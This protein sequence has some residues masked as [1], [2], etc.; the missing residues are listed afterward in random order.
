MRDFLDEASSSSSPVK[1][2]DDNRRR[3]LSSSLAVRDEVELREATAPVD[4]IPDE[5][6]DVEPRGKCDCV[7]H[8][9]A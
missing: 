5:Y 6:D 7:P 1:D 2:N 3:A 9:C 4:D 8:E